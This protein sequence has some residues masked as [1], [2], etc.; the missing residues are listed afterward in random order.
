MITVR[1]SRW[2]STPFLV[3]CACGFLRI[4]VDAADIGRII[5]IH[6]AVAPKPK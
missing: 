5:R 2:P 1:P 6:W 4:E 3:D